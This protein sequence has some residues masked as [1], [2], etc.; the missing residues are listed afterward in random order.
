MLPKSEVPTQ[1][2]EL[3]DL[4]KYTLCVSADVDGTVSTRKVGVVS[5]P[6]DGGFTETIAGA[7]GAVE[8]RTTVKDVPHGL[9]LPAPSLAFVLNL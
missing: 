9:R 1:T 7:L 8:S 5:T 2:L 3:V 6:G 4:C